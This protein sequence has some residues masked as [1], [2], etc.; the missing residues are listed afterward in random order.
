M[1]YTA[2]YFKSK[3]DTTHLISMAI[4]SNLGYISIYFPNKKRR[5]NY[6]QQINLKMKNSMLRPHISYTVHVILFS[7]S[8]FG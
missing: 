5:Q 2:S 3:K 7:S 4:S 8:N 6:P 1:A